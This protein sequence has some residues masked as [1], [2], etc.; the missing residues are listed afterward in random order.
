MFSRF[1]CDLQR[2]SAGHYELRDTLI[3]ANNFHIYKSLMFVL[4][5]LKTFET[6]KVIAPNAKNLEKV[7]LNKNTGIYLHNMST[8]LIYTHIRYYKHNIGCLFFKN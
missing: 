8:L 7:F 6:P 5:H 2:I 4:C 3:K 1:H